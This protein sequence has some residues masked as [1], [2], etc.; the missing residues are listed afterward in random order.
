[1]GE[2]FSYEA[3]VGLV[4]AGDMRRPSI[5][6]VESAGAAVRMVMAAYLER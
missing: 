5:I 6:A 4:A 1:L 3:F 2:D